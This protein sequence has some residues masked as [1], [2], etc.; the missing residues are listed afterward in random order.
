MKRLLYILLMSLCLS[1][2]ITT[3]DIPTD[4]VYV[5]SPT[6]VVYRTYTPY[7]Y[8]PHLWVSPPRV[9]HK[10]YYKHY[11]HYPHHYKKQ[12]RY[13]KPKPATSKPSHKPRPSKPHKSHRGNSR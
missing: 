12:Y 4:R 8:A 3:A 2:C 7:L 13:S 1:S 9:Y 10:H 11:Y 6:T 5:D